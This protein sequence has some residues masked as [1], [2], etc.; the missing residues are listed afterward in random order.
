MISVI[1]GNIGFVLNTTSEK[2]AEKVFN[3]YKEQSINNSGRAAGESVIMMERGEII[4]EF[5][6]SLA[7]NSN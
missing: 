3:D 7:E 2:Q 5:T 6:G 1:V 4:K